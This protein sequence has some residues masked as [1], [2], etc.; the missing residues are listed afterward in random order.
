MCRP[1]LCTRC[2]ATEI[3]P[4]DCGCNCIGSIVVEGAGDEGS[5]QSNEIRFRRCTMQCTVVLVEAAA[6]VASGE[7]KRC[8][9]YPK[10]CLNEIWAEMVCRCGSLCSGSSVLLAEVCSLCVFWADGWGELGSTRP[11]PDSVSL[12]GA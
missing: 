6:F 2:Y 7:G 11:G 4:S 12:P 9:L 1:G 3:I 5:I 8:H 10:A